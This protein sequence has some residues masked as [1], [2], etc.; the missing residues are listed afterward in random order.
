MAAATLPIASLRSPIT[1]QSVLHLM[2]QVK[3]EE[4]EAEAPKEK[5]DMKKVPEHV[6][7]MQE[8]LAKRQ[9]VEEE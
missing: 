8:A 9:E 2:G 6:R 1:N 7:E 3:E 4:K 5:V